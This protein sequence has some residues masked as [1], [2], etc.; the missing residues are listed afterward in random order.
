MKNTHLL[1]F[2]FALMSIQANL[3]AQAVTANDLAGKWMLTKIEVVKMQGDTEF[4]RQSYTI[5]NYPGKIYFEQVECFSDGKAIYSGNC[6]AGLLSGGGIQLHNYNL[7][8]YITFNGRAMGVRFEFQWLDK[9]SSFMLINERLLNQQS[10]EK[11]K[12]LLH[13]KRII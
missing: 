8:D 12:I 4:D 7:R 2:I 3:H 9:P 5:S 13:Y 1:F 10:R 11:E 6:D